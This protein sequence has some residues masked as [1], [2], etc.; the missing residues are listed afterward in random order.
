[1]MHQDGRPLSAFPDKLVA[2]QQPFDY[3]KEKL[4]QMIDIINSDEFGCLFRRQDNFSNAAR[5]EIDWFDLII[6][7]FGKQAADQIIQDYSMRYDE[8]MPIRANPF[9]FIPALNSAGTHTSNAL[10]GDL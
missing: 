2:N 7:L 9:D 8:D 10:A 5:L 1:M 6:F 4:F 3:V